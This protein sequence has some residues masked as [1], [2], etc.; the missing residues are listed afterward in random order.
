MENFKAIFRKHYI[1]IIIVFMS[2]IG[3]VTL[4]VLS[5]DN[6]AKYKKYNGLVVT[7]KQGNSYMI[8][9]SQYNFVIHDFD[10]NKM[11]LVE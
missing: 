5:K 6:D 11:R 2:L 1:S 4:T 10:V 9:G 8:R 7:D 3:L